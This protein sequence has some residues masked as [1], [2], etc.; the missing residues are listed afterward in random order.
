[1]GYPPLLPEGLHQKTLDEVQI[2]CV[3][4]F[5]CSTSRARLLAGLWTLVNILATD[6]ICG[7]LWVGGSFLT[8]KLNPRDVDVVLKLADVTARSPTRA[9]AAT[10]GW[11]SA[12]ND[13]AKAKKRTLYGIDTYLFREQHVP[14]R[15]GYWLR[16]FGRDRRNHPKGIV[17]LQLDDV[18]SLSIT[19]ML[20]GS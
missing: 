15:R 14:N 20:C 19:R 2:L 17:V 3:N 11:V 6:G 1:M 9:Q 18:R 5:P 10:L 12:R 4:A 7:E 16:R 13:V 8:Q